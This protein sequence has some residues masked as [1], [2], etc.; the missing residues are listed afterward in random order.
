MNNG[1]NGTYKPAWPVWPIIPF[2]VLNRWKP[3]G[4]ILRKKQEMRDAQEGEGKRKR[5]R[6]AQQKRDVFHALP[7]SDTEYVVDPSGLDHPTSLTEQFSNVPS[8]CGPRPLD[9]SLRIALPR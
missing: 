8:S 9:S 1:L 4:I 6:V 3:L 5:A 2:P 7:D